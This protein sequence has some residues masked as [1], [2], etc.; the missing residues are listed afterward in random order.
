MGGASTAAEAARLETNVASNVELL[1]ILEVMVNGLVDA[2]AGS[3]PSGKSVD[4]DGVSLSAVS[5]GLDANADIAAVVLLR[6]TVGTDVVTVEG[7]SNAV[8]V[9]SPA[10]L[11]G[12]PVGAELVLSMAVDEELDVGTGVLLLRKIVGTEEMTVAVTI[13]DVVLKTVVFSSGLL[14]KSKVMDE[15]TAGVG[16]RTVVS[17]VGPPE[18]AAVGSAVILVVLGSTDNVML[19]GKRRLVAFAAGKDLVIDRVAGLVASVAEDR[20]PGATMKLVLTVPDVKV[21]VIVRVNTTG[22]SAAVP[23]ISAVVELGTLKGTVSKL[24]VVV[25]LTWLKSGLADIAMVVFAKLGSGAAEETR[26][27]LLDEAVKVKFIHIED[28]PG[29]DTVGRSIV[30]VNGEGVVKI[31]VAECESSVLVKFFDGPRLVMIGTG[32]EDNAVGAMP[33]GAVVV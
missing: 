7:V 10:V 29:G 33:G 30:V 9:N 24:L 20:V 6:R 16:V 1:S 28:W 17:R 22:D 19:G 18:L 27:W 4:S 23:F 14:V 13:T 8:D 11:L 25:G 31:E 3:V 21:V 26:P 15:G 5:T 32:T 12:N 2:M